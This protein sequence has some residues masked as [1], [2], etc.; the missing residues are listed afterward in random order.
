M[1]GGGLT[2]NFKVDHK[3]KK[4]KI[5][6]NVRK[7]RK[8]NAGAR[9][10]VSPIQGDGKDVPFPTPENLWDEWLPAI[11]EYWT[12]MREEKKRKAEDRR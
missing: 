6:V 9:S 10:P 1:W 7:F 12:N 2:S 11:Q 3:R 8:N 5:K 4:R